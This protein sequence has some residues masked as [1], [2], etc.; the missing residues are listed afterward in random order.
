MAAVMLRPWHPFPCGHHR[1]LDNVDCRGGCRECFNAR[2]REYMRKKRAENIRYG[3]GQKKPK[4]RWPP[5]R[6]RC[7]Y[8]LKG[9]G[10]T[11]AQIAQ[12]MRISRGAVASK[13]HRIARR[14]TGPVQPG[15]AQGPAQQRQAAG[16]VVSEPP[17]QS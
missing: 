14:A 17:A 9:R 10:M 11:L 1:D 4:E 16:A 7:L 13:L 5:E 12:V 8:E 2:M 3:R 15:R 6:V